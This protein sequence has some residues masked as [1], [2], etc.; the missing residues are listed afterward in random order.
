M[1]VSSMTINMKL[2]V[3]HSRSF[4]LSLLRESS[5]HWPDAKLF[6][7]VLLRMCQPYC[8]WW[9]MTTNLTSLIWAVFGSYMYVG[10]AWEAGYWF[11]S[12][13]ILQVHKTGVL[14]G[15]HYDCKA[16]YIIK[17]IIVMEDCHSQT[18][19][20][21]VSFSCETARNMLYSTRSNEQCHLVLGT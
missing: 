17:C 3:T 5:N 9:S 19:S 16:R 14:K 18:R 20:C 15:M 21:E 4:S 8:V 6:T 13:I 10:R 1:H 2:S 11:S 12:G 7:R